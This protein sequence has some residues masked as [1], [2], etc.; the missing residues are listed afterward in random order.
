MKTKLGGLSR[1]QAGNNAACCA[2]ARP[3]DDA[4]EEF[5]RY[6]N[7]VT[8]VCTARAILDAIEKRGL[9][10]KTKRAR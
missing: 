2:L 8:L 9:E 6:A 4:L 10:F 7:V 3:F 5:L 1:R